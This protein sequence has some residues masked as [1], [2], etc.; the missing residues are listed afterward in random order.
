MKTSRAFRSK[1]CLLAP[2]FENDNK[3]MERQRKWAG[4]DQMGV[5]TY[6]GHLGS[7]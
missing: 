5:G 2:I 3:E 1:G 6:Q 4:R 7:Y